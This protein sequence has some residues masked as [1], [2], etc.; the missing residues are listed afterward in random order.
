[1]ADINRLSMQNASSKL[2]LPPPVPEPSTSKGMNRSK[3][4]RNL[5]SAGNKMKGLFKPK[6]KS[7]KGEERP[8][9]K[10]SKSYGPGDYVIYEEFQIP[11]TMPPVNIEQQVNPEDE[12]LQQELEQL[13]ELIALRASEIETEKARKEKLQVELAEA[14][15][16]YR[17]REVE[18][19]AIEQSFFEH[20]RTIRATDDDL[21]TIRD[22]FK[23]LKYS[24]ARLIMTLSKK[25]DKAKAADKFCKTWPHLRILEAPDAELESSLVNLLSEKLVHEHL[26]TS[27]FNVPVYPGLKVNEAYDALFHWLQAHSSQF[28]VRLRQQ[29]ASVIAKS[30][31]ESDIQQMAIK[32]K[33]RIATKIYDDLAD[34]YHPF[35]RENDAAVEDEKSYFNKICD[36]VEKTLKL[37]IAIRGQDVEITTVAIE[38]GKQEFEE[39]TMT[40]VKGRTSGVVRFSICPTFIGG[41]REHGFLEKGKV[42]VSN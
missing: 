32:E 35:L 20:T 8:A 37:A 34:I 33:Q 36:I 38:E 5:N 28:S 3:T 29:M 1:M 15:R 17:E 42:V 14:Q 9:I 13:N 12:Q 18:Y 10:T 7:K 16:I 30:G 41:D 39:E 27:I 4:V 2:P 24:I 40:E 23:L 19:S 11:E 21:S 31:K 6:E 25:A 26:V 22:S